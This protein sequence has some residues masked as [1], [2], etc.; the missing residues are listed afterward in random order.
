MT[1]TDTQGESAEIVLAPRPSPL[2]SVSERWPYWPTSIAAVTT[3]YFQWVSWQWLAVFFILIILV[4][5]QRLASKRIRQ[6]QLYLKEHSKLADPSIERRRVSEE[7]SPLLNTSLEIGRLLQ[8]VEKADHLAGL[9]HLA[10]PSAKIL[11]EDSV[12]HSRE[13]DRVNGIV[14]HILTTL[15]QRFSDLS[16]DY[17]SVGRVSAPDRK[18][19]ESFRA[20]VRESLIAFDASSSTARQAVWAFD[21]PMKD[22]LNGVSLDEIF[23]RAR[24]ELADLAEI[25]GEPLPERRYSLSRTVAVG[26]FVNGT[27]A[28]SAAVVCVTSFG[29]AF[30]PVIMPAFVASQGGVVAWEALY[31]SGKDGDE[32]S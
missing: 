15:T 8:L 31:G 26:S 25:R 11:G 16:R 29:C 2:V 5:E 19:L 27:L 23:R 22:F 18:A 4:L 7:L 14:L 1:E 24:G 12:W 13:A 20:E 17:G 10:S 6:I 28:L 3:A 9:G 30:S 32:A 21:E